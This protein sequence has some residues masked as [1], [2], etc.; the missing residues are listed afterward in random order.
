[1]RRALILGGTAAAVVGGALTA[2]GWRFDP[3]GASY[4]YLFAYTYVFTLTVGALFLLLI[5]QAADAR[6]F[7]AVRRL[8]EHVVGVLPALAVLFVPVVLSMKHL[9]P[10]D[11]VSELEPHA[12]TL[13]L[14]KRA[15]LNEPS[16]VARAAAYF[17]VFLTLGELLRRWSL[18][19]D[20]EG[21]GDGRLR[22][23][24]IGLAAGG[25]PVLAL[26]STFASFDWLMS[27]EPTWFSD[28][29]G[30]YLFAG[31]FV[32]ALG[33]VGAMLVIARSRNAL[34]PGVGAEHFH[35][36][37]RLELAMVIFWS[38][39]VWAQLVL[40]WIADMPLEVT[41]YIARSRGGWQWVGAG[42]LVLH[43]VIPF[44]LLLSRALKRK[45]LPFV[46]VSAWLV[47]VHLL[48][49]YYLVL[50][51]LEPAHFV[52]RWTD[53]TAVAA[54]GGASLA[55]GAFRA[56]DIIAYPV[57]DPLLDESIRYEAA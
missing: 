49:V 48:D 5:G 44:A 25:L 51:A 19:Q 40:Q 2:L 53:L 13:V 41:W 17:V 29:Y 6:W 46:T 47:V 50:P 21:D 27:L 4:S 35:A 52:V 37:G 9:Y 20:R 33:L 7:V 42:L 18:R 22:R 11:R 38:Y 26:T 30:V 28:I 15:W 56:R 43:F 24:M 10:W 32:S 54:L 39:I 34:P 1:V 45:P 14:E 57:G 16:Y 8:T 36:I 55:F 23:R 3:R 12:R 31:G